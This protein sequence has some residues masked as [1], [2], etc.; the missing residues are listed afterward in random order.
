MLSERATEPTE[1]VLSDHLQKDKILWVV[2]LVVVLN[3]GIARFNKHRK[4]DIGDED[5]I[6]TSKKRE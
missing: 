1:I 3:N 2:M 4:L 5:F 6:L